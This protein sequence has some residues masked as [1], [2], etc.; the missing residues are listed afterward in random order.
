MLLNSLQRMIGWLVN[1]RSVLVSW[2]KHGKESS[3]AQSG[4]VYLGK[5]LFNGVALLVGILTAQSLMDAAST[6]ERSDI[7]TEATDLS[8]ELYSSEPGR[9]EFALRGYELLV[10][11]YRNDDL[12]LDHVR[13][14]ITSYFERWKNGRLDASQTEKTK[15]ILAALAV[16]DELGAAGW[17][18]ATSDDARREDFRW[19]EGQR[20]LDWEGA[21]DPREIFLRA[22]FANISLDQ[23]DLSCL[24]LNFSNFE[25]TDLSN[26]DLSGSSFDEANFIN[27]TIQTTK[28]RNANLSKADFSIASIS[29][30]DFSSIDAPK[31]EK[32]GGR[33]SVS[34]LNRA[35]FQDA[36]L[37][38]VSFI[39]TRLESVDF[40]LALLTNVDFRKADGAY[41]IFKGAT[42]QG[43]TFDRASFRSADYAGA[44]LSGTSF[45][46]ANL[47]AAD[48]RG[49]TIADTE[50]FASIM[51]ASDLSR[52]NFSGVELPEGADICALL[53]R[54][55]VL[56][57]DVDGWKLAGR[58]Q[59]AARFS[60]QVDRQTSRRCQAT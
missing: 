26:V 60:S 57:S 42:L 30:T 14:A 1:S 53:K 50:T 49:A 47:G 43:V 34:D 24:G 28:F 45:D 41:A 31:C 9:R 44:F 6:S 36:G 15:E 39:G 10:E 51:D 32:F 2:A 52:A 46:E 16:V 12:A 5:I 38:N 27:S 18:G 3:A 7:R 54:G 19:I 25:G 4:Y 56:V 48:F 23:V 17:Y 40:S 8:A 55:A 35:R 20:P 21:D 58:P 11:K 37:T 22:P 59:N 33:S 13:Q 29:L